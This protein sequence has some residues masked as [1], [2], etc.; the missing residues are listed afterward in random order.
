MTFAVFGD[1]AVD[2]RCDNGQRHRAEFEHGIAESAEPR[3]SNARSRR[4]IEKT[5][6]G[7]QRI[8]SGL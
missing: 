1:E 3:I 8:I 5:T 6:A 4:C 7:D 2:P